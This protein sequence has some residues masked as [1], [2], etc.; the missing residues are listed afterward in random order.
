M[1][2]LTRIQTPARNAARAACGDP[3]NA[4]QRLKSIRRAARFL[5]TVIA[6]ICYGILMLQEEVM[7][8]LASFLIAV[9]IV[10]GL[11]VTA[12]AHDRR[13]H[14][15]GYRVRVF[16]TY[17]VRTIRVVPV[18][19]A[20]VLGARYYRPYYGYPYNYGYQRS[21]YVHR[22]NWERR[23]WRRHLRRERRLGRIRWIN[24]HR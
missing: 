5:G 18:R 15:R 10:L 23:A 4:R 3:I 16:R 13:W 24:R 1:Q 12:S 6:D 22:R 9:S 14:H 2:G 17:P 21:A 11:A 20:R 7:R 8:K 19:R